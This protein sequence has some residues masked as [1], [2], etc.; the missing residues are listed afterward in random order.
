MGD[1]LWGLAFFAAG[2]VALVLLIDWYVN[3]GRVQA[4]PRQPRCTS[5]EDRLL[6]LDPKW[7]EEELDAFDR[8]NG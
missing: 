1:C 6:D 2:G 5:V 3:Y 4:L 8:D 7:V